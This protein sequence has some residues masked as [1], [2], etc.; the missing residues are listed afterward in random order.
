MP[1]KYDRV[2]VDY[3]NEPLTKSSEQRNALGAHLCRVGV[4]VEN[5]VAGGPQDIEG[6]FVMDGQGNGTVY[7]VQT[8]PFTM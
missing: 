3:S 7:V 6:C 1:G 2:A 5:A 4:A 8:R